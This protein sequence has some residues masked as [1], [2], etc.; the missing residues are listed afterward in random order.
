MAS[1]SFYFTS[2]LLQWKTFRLK[3]NEMK[4]ILHC[5]STGIAPQCVQ[6]KLMFFIFE[7]FYST[8]FQNSLD[9]GIHFPLSHTFL[10]MIKNNPTGLVSHITDSKCDIAM[11]GQLLQSMAHWFQLVSLCHS[12]FELMQIYSIACISAFTQIWIHVFLKSC[13]WTSVSVNI[14]V[15]HKHKHHILI[16][17]N[18]TYLVVI[19]AECQ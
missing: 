15:W 3:W 16:M 1:P 18:N 4:N 10:Y 9:P 11:P 17:P 13:W 14:S 19:N 8:G 12:P 5:N 7:L 2:K 6:I